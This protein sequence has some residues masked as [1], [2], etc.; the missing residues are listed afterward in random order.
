MSESHSEEKKEEARVQVPV[1]KVDLESNVE[2]SVAFSL[3]DDWAKKLGKRREKTS[4]Y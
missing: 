1:L 2:E 4:I 3:L